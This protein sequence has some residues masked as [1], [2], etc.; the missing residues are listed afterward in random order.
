LHPRHG[1]SLGWAVVEQSADGPAGE[2]GVDRFPAD[3][4]AGEGRVRLTG[5][6]TDLD[7]VGAGL[8]DADRATWVGVFDREQKITAV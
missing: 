5:P 4:N 3:G 6:A 2:V 7:M 8:G 1:K